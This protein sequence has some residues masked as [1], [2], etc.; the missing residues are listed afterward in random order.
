MS[1]KLI[2]QSDYT[3]EQLKKLYVEKVKA[4][5]SKNFVFLEQLRMDCPQL[6]EKAFLYQM[7]KDELANTQV[8]LPD[9]IHKLLQLEVDK[10]GYKN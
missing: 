6:F 9:H 2:T 7:L 3:H 5:Q 10:T 4:S 8:D 1:K